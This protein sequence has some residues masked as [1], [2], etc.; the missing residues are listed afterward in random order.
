[1][2]L[3]FINILLLFLLSIILGSNYWD[4][5]GTPSDFPRQKILDGLDGWEID[6]PE[7][8]ISQFLNTST[9][10]IDFPFPEIDSFNAFSNNDELYVTL[11]L[12][13]PIQ[14]PPKYFNIENSNSNRS[15][16][17]LFHGILNSQKYWMIIDI[18]S[19]YDAEGIDGGHDYVVS[20]E[21]NSITESWTKEIQEWKP[22]G[23]LPYKIL[24]HEENY[25]F[26][27]DNPFIE[28]HLPYKTIGFPTEYELKFL[29]LNDFIID[30]SYF[31]RAFD[32]SKQMHIPPPIITMT[33][34]IN[35]IELRPGENSIIELQIKSE[36]G[37]EGSIPKVHLDHEKTI[38]NININYTKNLLYVPPKGMIST[39]L[40]IKIAD[41][42]V[43]EQY[44]L[45]IKGI[46]GFHSKFVPFESISD[47]Q[48]M[49]N[50][51]N[52][53]KYAYVTVKIDR[54]TLTEQIN[55]WINNW[56]NPLTGVWTTITTIGTGILGWRIW[57]KSKKDTNTNNTNTNT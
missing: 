34:S 36:T 17:H 48:T 44:T 9:N 40:N 26:S 41:N 47:Y 2:K 38:N 13:K 33:P 39:P 25:N 4:T 43:D 49:S 30:D 57:K 55:E 10:Y 7:I 11:W 45:I 46:V 15:L 18:D 50:D 8:M 21:W 35:H 19:A 6:G 52:L 29:I 54:L 3:I 27:K 14:E 5:F 22:P 31:V 24:S 28:F 53:V 56:F 23:S 42:A 1:M 32:V 37:G 51:Q 16:D 20:L 12:S